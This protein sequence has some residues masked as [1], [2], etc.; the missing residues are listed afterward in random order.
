MFY[1]MSQ[2]MSD[3][4]RYSFPAVYSQQLF[5]FTCMSRQNRGKGKIE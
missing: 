4:L 5:N 3:N 2:L 1:L